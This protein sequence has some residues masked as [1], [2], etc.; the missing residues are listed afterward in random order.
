M[1]LSSESVNDL[2]WWVTTLPTACKN[3]IM[4][5]PAIE[6]ATDASTLGWEAVCNGQS[7]QSM[8]SPLEKQKHI[9][10]LKLL[11]V[12]FGLQ[13]FLFLLKGKRVHKKSQ[14]YDCLLPQCN[15]DTKSPLCNKLAKSGWM[16]CVQNEIWLTACHLPGVLNFEADKS[17]RQF[18]ERIE[19]QLKP[20]IFLKI[21][22]IFSTP[23]ID[24]VA[25]RLNN[26]L[27]KC[28]S[29]KPDPGACHVD[30][31]SFSWS[32]KF[33]Y[34]FPPF[35]L[36]NRCLQKLENDQTSSLL[37]APVWPTQVC[38]PRLLSL[39]VANPLL[40]P[41]D[42]DLLIVPQSETVHPLR[43]QMRLLACLFSG[44][45]MKQEEYRSQLLDCSWYPWEEVLRNN[46]PGTS[47]MYSILSQKESQSSSAT[48][49]SS[50]GFPF[51]TVWQ[52]TYLQC[53]QLCQKRI[54]FLCVL[55][56]WLCSWT[57]P[58]SLSPVERCFP[59]TAT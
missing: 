12:Y 34:I 18:N 26:Q 56:R 42:N 40:L 59:V 32:G 5:N 27:P 10:E 51:C 53:Y 1:T 54:V 41:Q 46:T 2:S 14:L 19:W 55:G 9:N 3:I 33:V 20:G 15:G 35:F 39:L 31:F 47:K 44:N 50:L 13:S 37:I 48:C 6:L 23:E 43:N 16:C 4:G 21:I 24:L 49:S 45:P 57:E 58:A 52:R 17:S 28:V 38:W 22:D 11:T 25:C 30:A 29:W 7:A 8:W 36:L